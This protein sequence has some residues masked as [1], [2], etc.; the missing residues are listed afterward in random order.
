MRQCFLALTAVAAITAGASC[1]LPFGC[2]ER[3]RV[4]EITYGGPF[5]ATERSQLERAI[6]NGWDCVRDG[7]IRDARGNVIG[8][9]HI[10]TI[11]D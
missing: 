1:K 7:S 3:S 5:E 10:C 2:D 4:Y 11:C 9:R 6:E 8:E